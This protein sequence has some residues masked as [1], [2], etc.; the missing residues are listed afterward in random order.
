MQRISLLLAGFAPAVVVGQQS[1]GTELWRVAATTLPLPPALATGGAS[2]FWNP[3]QPIGPERALLALEVIETAPSVGAA[4]AL[5]SVRARLRPVGEVGLVYGRMSIG[6]L[7]RTSLSPDPDPGAIPYYTQALGAHWGTV[8]AGTALGATL[9]YHDTRLDVAGSSRWTINVGARRTFGDVVTLAATT[10]GFSRLATGDP[11]QDLYGGGG[12]RVWPGPLWVSRAAGGGRDGIAAAKSYWEDATDLP[13]ALRAELGAA[14]PLGRLALDTAQ[15]SRDG[16]EKFLWKLADGEAIESVLIP[17]GKRRTLCISSQVGCALGCVF[18]ATGR[19]GF[20]RNLTTA[21]IAAQVRELVLRDPAT[22]PTNVVFMGM[23]EPLLNWDA[24]DA[25]LTILNHPDGL[26]IGA[27]HIT[28][29]TV[30]ILPSLAQLARRPEQ[31]RLA[32][33]LHAPSAELRHELMPT[34]K[35]YRLPDLLQALGQFRRRVTLEYVLI[36][37]E[38]D[39]LAQADEL[40]SLARPLG[41]LVNLLPLHPGGAPDLMPSSRAQMLAFERRLKSRGVEAVL[42]RSR[43]LDISAA[44]GQLRVELEARRKVRPQEH[45][46]VE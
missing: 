21:E 8:L 26:G 19:M 39:S 29:S 4:G 35:K 15:Q 42:R 6:D 34:E 30:G 18:C 33:S 37:G 13:A 12:V 3:A 27:R 24:V 5:V 44:C 45:A 38:N 22:P 23:G 28:V 36:G 17:E 31:F 11:T 2:V 46:R 14:F 41:A 43:G 9:A 7:V 32:V 25:A 20:R 1:A 40:A 16:T 10:H